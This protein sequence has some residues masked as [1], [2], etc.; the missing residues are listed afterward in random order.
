MAKQ[1]H[2]EILKRKN[3]VAVWNKWRED[4]PNVIP[5]LNNLNAMRHKLYVVDYRFARFKVVNFN[6]INFINADLFQANLSKILL[7]NANLS[8]ANLKFTV[9]TESQMK[10]AVLKGAILEGAD[11]SSSDLTGANLDEI[12]INNVK[13]TGANLTETYMRN[14]ELNFAD[15][16]NSKLNR[17]DLSG[18]EL[19]NVSFVGADLRQAKLNRAKLINAKLTGAKLF[20]IQPYELRLDGTECLYAYLDPEGTQRTPKE[21]NF[22]PG[23]FDDFFKDYFFQPEAS[24]MFPTCFISYSH[25]NKAFAKKL[26]SDLQESGISCGY[27]PEDMKGGRKV[28][29]QIGDAIGRQDKLLLVLSED[30]MNSDWIAYEIKKARK[31]EKA[32]G[33]QILF[34]VRLVD[35]EAV[36]RWEL[37]HADTVTDLA[38]E[39]RQYFIPD[40]SDWDNPEEYQKAFDRLLADL[41]V[42]KRRA[43]EIH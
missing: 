25:T 9:L 1:A 31:R 17:A 29:E 37:F 23:E 10:S 4:H 34:P 36:K 6:G 30:S 35:W 18:S 8:G 27:A 21:R 22:Y 40:F 15:F 43:Q 20:G 39:V 38:E 24:T 26:W 7:R 11:L 12:R 16:C 14:S 13:L 2:V 41:K 33:R 32:E 42:R 5:K 28:H 3:G 19:F